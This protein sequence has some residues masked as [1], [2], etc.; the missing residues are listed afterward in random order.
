MLYGSDDRWCVSC[1]ADKEETM[2]AA[3]LGYTSHLVMMVS[4]YLDI[5]LRYPMEHRVSR[6]RIHDHILDKLTDKDREWV[7]QLSYVFR[8]L[9]G[10]NHHGYGLSNK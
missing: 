6:S 9:F 5:P 1:V 7:I 10:G 4:E 3:A 8:V 2:I